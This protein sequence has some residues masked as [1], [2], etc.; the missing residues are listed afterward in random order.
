M[1]VHWSF[2]VLMLLGG[3]FTLGG[4]LGILI[5]ILAHE[6]GHAFLVRACG[7]RATE[8]RLHWLGGECHYDPAWGTEL[9]RAIIAWGGV[10]AQAL[11]LWLT[12]RIGSAYQ[13]STG[14]W[15]ELAV[16]LVAVNLGMI[17]LNLIPMRGLDGEHAWSLFPLLYRLWRTRRRRA[18]LERDHG[19]LKRE[20]D[21]LRARR[22]RADDDD[23]II[24]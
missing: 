14:L 10:V 19:A 13:L 16:P 12:L 3:R 18:K 1:R 5:L 6:L 11:L 23:G 8:I 9:H 17:V 21:A 22:E 2:F 7:L 20:L 4:A 15:A 24:H